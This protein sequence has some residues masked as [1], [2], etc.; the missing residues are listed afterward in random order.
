MHTRNS[1]IQSNS[2]ECSCNIHCIA[3]NT[4]ANWLKRRERRPSEH[5][6]WG[7]EGNL[8]DQRKHHRAPQEKKEPQPLPSTNRW[9]SGKSLSKKNKFYVPPHIQ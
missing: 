1:K 4:I 2:T 9:Q 8:E 3:V 6:R 7:T 5:K